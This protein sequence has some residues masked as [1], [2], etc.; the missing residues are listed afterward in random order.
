MARSNALGS[1]LNESKKKDTRRQ[2]ALSNMDRH[3]LQRELRWWTARGVLWAITLLVVVSA[4][5]IGACHRAFNVLAGAD[6][7]HSALRCHGSFDTSGVGHTAP[8]APIYDPPVYNLDCLAAHLCS[9]QES[10]TPGS[11]STHARQRTIRC[12]SISVRGNYHPR[13]LTLHHPIDITGHCVGGEN[14]DNKPDCVV[15][16]PSFNGLP[17]V[18]LTSC[19][20]QQPHLL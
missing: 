18:A 19:F 6:L 5:V 11:E 9:F 10:R 14:V 20:N 7:S 12:E 1:W 16:A 15:L 8:I 4:D 13:S 2:E 3:K 17:F